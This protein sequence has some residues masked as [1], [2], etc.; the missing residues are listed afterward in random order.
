M[1]LAEWA[2][3]LD[4][5]AAELTKEPA[6]RGY[7]VIYGES[8]TCLDRESVNEASLLKQ[9]LVDLHGIKPKQIVLLQGS[10]RGEDSADEGFSFKSWVVPPGADLNE[11]IR[12]SRPIVVCRQGLNS[13]TRPVISSSQPPINRKCPDVV[14]KIHFSSR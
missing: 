7:L 12:K 8:G 13:K 2:D 11:T 3:S 14:D 1:L 9:Y 10:E 4:R 5:L 6:A